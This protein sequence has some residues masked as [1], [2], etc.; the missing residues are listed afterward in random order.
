MGSIFSGGTFIFTVEDADVTVHRPLVPKV[1][2]PLGNMMENGMK[3]SCEGSAV[4]KDVDKATFGRFGAF[5]YPGD[6]NPALPSPFRNKTV[7]TSAA[8]R[9][10]P[11]AGPDLQSGAEDPVV[12]LAPRSSRPPVN[13]KRNIDRVSAVI[14]SREESVPTRAAV[15]KLPGPTNNV[16]ITAPIPT[17]SK[18]APSWPGKDYSPVFVRH[19]RLYVFADM[20]AITDLKHLSARRLDEVLATFN[21]SNSGGTDISAFIK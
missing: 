21:Y 14:S 8:F 9:S 10:D 2:K 15:S 3:E 6:Y 7:P 16:I 1:S 12:I 19:A 4:L 11:V 18:F 17:R 20:Y 13:K 5:I